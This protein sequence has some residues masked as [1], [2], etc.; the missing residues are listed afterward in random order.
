MKRAVVALALA[1]LPSFGFA[2]TTRAQMLMGTICEIT[3][4]DENA[5]LIDKAFAEGK[6]IDDLLSTWRDD[7]TLARVNHGDLSGITPELRE[8][9]KT[10]LLWSDK[11]GGAFDPLVQPLVDAWGIRGKGAIP[12]PEALADAKAK[13]DP[14]NLKME[15]NGAITLA[16]GSAIDPGAF[17]KGFALDKMLAV[18]RSYGAQRA[19]INFGGQVAV[20]G[21]QPYVTIADPEHRDKPAVGLMLSTVSISTSS[22]SEKQFTVNGRTFTHLIDPR[23]GE[24]LP[25]RGSVSVLARTGVLADILSTALYV[26]GPEKGVEWARAN[27]VSAI[28][29]NADGK[30]VTTGRVPSLQVLIKEK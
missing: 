24:A 5:A 20:F 7:T 25:P 10:A 27:N 21:D 2:D 14:H 22:G 23:T 3:V 28:F 1:L 17:G 9:L 26:M 12:S 16:K 19:V 18:I 8:L 4:P 29:I 15:D 6:R 13:S 11:T 30:V